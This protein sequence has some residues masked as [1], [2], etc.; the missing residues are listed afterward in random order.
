M[1][2]RPC[3]MGSNKRMHQEVQ[4]VL[5]ALVREVGSLENWSD[6]LVVAKY[7]LDN[8]PGPHGFTPRDLREI[9]EFVSSFGK[10]RATPHFGV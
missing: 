7:V 8:T 3:E 2:L 5:G 10:G 1:A 9:L 4:K 6:W